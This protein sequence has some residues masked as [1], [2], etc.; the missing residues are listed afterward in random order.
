M[1]NNNAYFSVSQKLFKISETFELTGIIDPIQFNI[2]VMITGGGLFI[3]LNLFN[4]SSVLIK[5]VCVSVAHTVEQFKFAVDLITIE[6]FPPSSKKNFNLKFNDV[7]FYNFRVD[8]KVQILKIDYQERNVL[9]DVDENENNRVEDSFGSDDERNR[10]YSI[11]CQQ[12][13]VPFF[14]FFFEVKQIPINFFVFQIAKKSFHLKHKIEIE[15]NNLL[16]ISLAR[17][18]GINLQI[19]KF[20]GLFKH[21]AKSTF[22]WFYFSRVSGST[23]ALFTVKS[24]SKKLVREFKRFF[25]GNLTGI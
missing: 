19:D 17:N 6:N 12:I 1:T 7:S 5:D 18:L 25:E 11:N 20:Q 22:F 10:V 23:K 9:L 24:H 21:F 4:A 14:F 15:E 3:R 8:C 2:E 16:V 13:I